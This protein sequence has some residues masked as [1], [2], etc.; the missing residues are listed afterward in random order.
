[1]LPGVQVL[2]AFLLTVA[3]TNQFATLSSE[4]KGL[5]FG[6]VIAT[7][8]AVV[9]LLAPGAQHRM[10]F[11]EHDKEAL[12]R[13]ANRLALTAT[14]ATAMAAVLFLVANYIYDLI[15]AS[16]AT[17]V[18]VGVMVLLWYVLPWRRRHGGG[19]GDAED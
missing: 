3:F 8:L 4:E 18:L 15:V 12:L 10:R 2:L 1:M 6:A 17:A 16:I 14:V 9:L 13:S 19:G 11:R 7:S 5:Y